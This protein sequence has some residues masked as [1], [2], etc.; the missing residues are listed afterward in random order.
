MY[1]PVFVIK[2]KT[3]FRDTWLRTL[4]CKQGW[5]DRQKTMLLPSLKSG[6]KGLD[7]KDKLFIFVIVF[8]YVSH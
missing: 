5:A 2:Y 8:K 4:E 6:H 3:A 1:K 7:A